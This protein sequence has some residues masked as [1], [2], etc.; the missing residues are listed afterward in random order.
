[1]IGPKRPTS[2]QSKR[3][4]SFALCLVATS[5]T[6]GHLP[7]QTETRTESADASKGT[8]FPEGWN[9]TTG[10]P[11]G[12]Q[13]RGS[14]VCTGCH[15]SIA[16]TQHQ[17]PMAQASAAADRSAILTGHPTLTYRDGPYELRIERQGGKEIYSAKEGNHIVSVPLLWAFGQGVAG[18][19]YIYEKLGNYY[20]SR[21]SYYPEI[22]GLDLTTGHSQETPP[23]L[24]EALGRPMA[25][26]EVT[27]CF[28]C[29]TSEDVFDG[30]LGVDHLQP[31]VTCENCHGPGSQHLKALSPENLQNDKFLDWNI[32]NP[33][34]LD[35]ADLNDFC[36]TCH[37]S[38]REVLAAKIQ[39]IRNV[40]FQPYRLDN[41]RCYDPADKRIT[42]LACHDPH[43]NLVTDLPSY[44][45]KCLACHVNKNEKQTPVRSAPPC[46]KATANC[47]SCHMPKLSLPGAHYKFTDHYIRIDHANAPYPD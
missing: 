12:M 7:A 34:R 23:T 11:Q 16:N 30:K 39:G 47:V 35:P 1:M 4:A 2:W 21:V 19:T 14:K 10:A 46:S 33:A 22:G 45:A 29:H 40:R 5:A 27:K 32:L 44:D 6:S 15:S 36:G 9:R 31:G 26:E 3:L 43:V 37:R 17:T 25:K 38:T 13:Y 24:E 8:H 41:S 18:Q 20:E 28:T 42:C